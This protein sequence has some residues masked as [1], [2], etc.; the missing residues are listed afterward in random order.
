M[1][2]KLIRRAMSELC[3]A[4]TLDEVRQVLGELFCRLGIDQYVFISTG[5]SVR[6]AGSP[7]LV[8]NY[9][10]RW[11]ALYR[12]H[13]YQCNDPFAAAAPL[14]PSLSLVRAELRFARV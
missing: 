1:E 9:D 6:S 2:L 11:Q 4:G 7:L 5:S 10:C 13:G 12:S 14:S 3:D 8:S